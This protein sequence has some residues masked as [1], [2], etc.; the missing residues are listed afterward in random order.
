MRCDSS[1]IGSA[2]TS[3]CDD[4]DNEGMNCWNND[5][6]MEDEALREKLAT[7]VFL[8]KTNQFKYVYAVNSLPAKPDVSTLVICLPV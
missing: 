2:G 8:R 4:K 5:C 3:V 1:E 7:A 6:N